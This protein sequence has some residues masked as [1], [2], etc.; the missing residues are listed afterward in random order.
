MFPGQ[1]ARPSCPRDS[2]GLL[3]EVSTAGDPGPRLGD[4]DRDLL[5]HTNRPTVRAGAGR[6]GQA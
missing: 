6:L 2:R 4:E 3:G 1:V 5:A